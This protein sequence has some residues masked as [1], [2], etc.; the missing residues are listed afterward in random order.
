MVKVMDIMAAGDDAWVAMRTGGGTR[1]CSDTTC[2]APALSLPH[3]CAPHTFV[4]VWE[5]GG[6][7]GR[8]CVGVGGGEWEGE[9]GVGVGICGWAGGVVGVA[10]WVGWVG[11][12]GVRGCVGA[13]GW[14]GGWAGERWMGG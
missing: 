6:R 4:V 1:V 2:R 13:G 3:P 11:M 10:V 7:E 9:M 5:R 12:G 8:V 14:V